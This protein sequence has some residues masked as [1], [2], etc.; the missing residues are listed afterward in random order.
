M[1]HLPLE[2]TRPN[3]SHQPTTCR[4]LGRRFR[5]SFCATLRVALPESEGTWRLSERTLG[6]HKVRGR[7]L[8]SRDWRSVRQRRTLVQMLEFLETHAF[9]RQIVEMMSDAD[10]AALQGA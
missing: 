6:A 7:N 5:A 4:S 3:S 2:F 8:T 1:L 10:Y 9:T